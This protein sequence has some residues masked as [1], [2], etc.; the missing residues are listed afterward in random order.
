MNHV[1]AHTGRGDAFADPPALPYYSEAAERAEWIAPER[2][3][4]VA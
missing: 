2:S 3:E 4:G 1:A